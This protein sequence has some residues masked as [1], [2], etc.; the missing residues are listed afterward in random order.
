M[1]LPRTFGLLVKIEETRGL[2]F[3][4]FHLKFPLL[5][6][7]VLL[8]RVEELPGAGRHVPVAGVAIA[9]VL[10]ELSN[11]FESLHRLVKVARQT[12]QLSQ[13]FL[14]R[15]LVGLADFNDLT[16]Q[17]AKSFEISP[18]WLGMIRR[19]AFEP[20]DLSM[21]Q[22]WVARILT[23]FLQLLGSLGVVPAMLKVP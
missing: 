3:F 4:V 14:V 1:V 10:V 6:R 9:A 17:G 22:E 13:N 18:L 5:C 19:Y 2:Q 23:A 7:N 16:S 20:L 15:L 11:Y 21:A 8:T 12:L